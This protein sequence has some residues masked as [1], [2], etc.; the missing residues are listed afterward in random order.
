MVKSFPYIDDFKLFLFTCLQH[1]FDI[2][3]THSLNSLPICDGPNKLVC[4]ND[5]LKPVCAFIS[6]WHYDVFRQPNLCL[7][8][9]DKLSLQRI[10]K[11]KFDCVNL[12]LEMLKVLK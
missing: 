9:M 4:R 12:P 6:V 10:W 1:K 11:G 5:A 7:K 8:Q 2:L 3:I